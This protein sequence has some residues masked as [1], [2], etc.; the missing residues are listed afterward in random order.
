MTF[1]V[2]C[3]TRGLCSVGQIAVQQQSNLPEE[4]TAHVSNAFFFELEYQQRLLRVP[5]YRAAFGSNQPFRTGQL[6]SDGK[7]EAAELCR[8]CATAREL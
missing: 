7:Q 1:S 8:V 2:A 6:E 3:P 5:L 4:Q